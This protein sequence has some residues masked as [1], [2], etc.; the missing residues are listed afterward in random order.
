MK[1]EQLLGLRDRA[2]PRCRA[3]TAPAA[4]VTAGRAVLEPPVAGGQKACGQAFSSSAPLRRLEGVL[5]WVLLCCP[6]CRARTPPTRALLCRWG[7]SH[8]KKRPGWVLVCRSV[9][10]AL[11][12][13]ASPAQPP[14]PACREPGHGDGRTPRWHCLAR[15]RPAFLPRRARHRPLPRVPS[16]PLCG[17]R[18]RSP[19][20]CSAA[21][22]SRSGH[23]RP[24][25]RL[26]QARPGLVRL[27]CHGSAASLSP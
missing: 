17:R 27:D 22:D 12:G 1:L 6:G 4:G 23:C 20:D 21:A 10:Q 16:P 9:G 25:R 18:R 13:P 8:L 15:R 2:A 5:A 19:G 11:D 7:I 24:G 3:R 26:P 14:T